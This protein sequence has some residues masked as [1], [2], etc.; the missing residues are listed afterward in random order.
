MPCGSEVFSVYPVDFFVE[1]IDIIGRW[2]AI[3]GYDVDVIS[4]VM[5]E[6][7]VESPSL[8]MSNLWFVNRC[9]SVWPTYCL[10]H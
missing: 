5:G 8:W 10:L 4:G 1:D 6:V 2:E 3:Y 7:E 9:L